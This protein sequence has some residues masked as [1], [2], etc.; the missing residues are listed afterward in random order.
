MMRIGSTIAALATAVLWAGAAS[1]SVLTSKLNVDNGYTIYISTSDNTAGTSFGS[2]EDWNNTYTDT[3]T[4]AAGTDYFIHIRAYD[5]G[6]MAGVLG[7]F[8]L[9]GTGHHFANGTTSLT[10]DTTAWLGNDNGFSSP[11]VALSDLGPNGIGPWGTISGVSSGAR[12]IWAGDASNN[13]VTYLTAR[14]FA[15]AVDPSN[16]VPEPGSLVL[17]GAAILA[18]VRTRSWKR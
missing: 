1:A 2:A 9:A 7:E 6:G 12:W 13:D 11:Y 15:D 17:M 3:T 4:L 8:S 14:I 5:T 18:L 10:T 16:N